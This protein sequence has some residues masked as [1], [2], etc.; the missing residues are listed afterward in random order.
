MLSL[1]ESCLAQVGWYTVPGIPFASPAYGVAFP[2]S[3]RAIF[4]GR[5]G[6]MFWSTDGGE[7]WIQLPSRTASY[8]R[9]VAIHESVGLTVGDNGTIL[10]STNG[11]TAWGPASAGTTHDLYGVAFASSRVAFAVGGSGTILRSTDAGETWL[12]VSSG[13]KEE[14]RG[15][16]FSDVVTGVI[17]GGFRKGVLLRTR[18]GGGVWSRVSI[19]DGRVLYAV[20]LSPSAGLG[21][22]AGLGGR[23]M[24]TKDAGLTWSDSTLIANRFF[25][26][27]CSDAGLMSVAGYGVFQSSDSGVSWQVQTDSYVHS[28]SAADM[29]NRLA[30]GSSIIRTTSS[31]KYGWERKAL[32]I[33]QTLRDV[34]LL[35]SLTC[36]AVGDSGIIARTTD[37]GKSWLRPLSR[38]TRS[39]KGI[40]ISRSVAVAVGDSGT[41][42]R[43][44]DAGA[45]WS[46]HNSGMNK[47][48]RAVH[49][50]NERVVVAVGHEGAILRSSDTGQT[51]HSILYP[52]P[53]A[54]V[55][56]SFGDSLHGVA[57]LSSTFSQRV[58]RTSN[59]GLSW[60]DSIVSR[61]D[62][63]ITK[64][65]FLT[66][67]GFGYVSTMNVQS[68]ILT[69]PCT[70]DFG[71]TWFLD[72]VGVS[73]T[74]SVFC[75]NS[76][77]VV[78]A[79]ND[80]SIL[81]ST[82]GGRTWESQNTGMRSPL[83]AVSYVGSS[84]GV[85]VGSGGQLIWTSTAGV[86]QPLFE[87]R[88]PS[89]PDYLSLSQNFP[90]PFNASTTITF[91][92]SQSGFVELQV[93]NILGEQVAS[94]IRQEMSAGDHVTTWDGGNGASG[95][96]FYRLIVGGRQIV[97]KL[98]LIR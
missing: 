93:C 33:S 63:G 98:L 84:T 71:R 19:D 35:D 74:N 26:A 95:M 85:A 48:L 90:N 45:H 60:T 75:S 56:V 66:E 14:L 68:T 59:G 69:T 20:S 7:H 53:V 49:I 55:S 18:N 15:V 30:V 78:F 67:S 40:D 73:R 94:L 2:D 76:G 57:L 10:R 70:R 34:V 77:R 32:G 46:S 37:A 58:L 97:R 54:L 92:L 83:L 91:Q 24:V 80:G 51:W 47:N 29:N 1:T 86:P 62:F 21:V 38:T 81:Q 25:G 72:T 79:G 16:S 43:S 8:L 5:N 64:E 23:V 17:V 27:W 88:I 82:D 28:I 42:L 36:L 41:I 9:A 31:G 3:S 12:P 39:L 89:I 13:T 87:E 96:Y 11:G 22:A 65:V 6:N 4:V 44:T 52:I 50:V 61:S